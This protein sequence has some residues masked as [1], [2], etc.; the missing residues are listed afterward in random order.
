[1]RKQE[2]TGDFNTEDN[3]AL[4]PEQRKDI[5]TEL[6]WIRDRL[7][8]LADLLAIEVALKPHYSIPGKAALIAASHVEYVRNALCAAEKLKALENQL[9]E[10]RPYDMTEVTHRAMAKHP[11]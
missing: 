10:F 1:M 5:D 6:L 3:M 11:R 2:A 9:Q 7:L 8:A 4:T